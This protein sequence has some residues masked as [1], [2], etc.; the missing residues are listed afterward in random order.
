MKTQMENL[1]PGNFVSARERAVLMGK[2]GTPPPHTH[3]TR[4]TNQGQQEVGEKNISADLGSEIRRG[5]LLEATLSTLFAGE[6][7]Q[8]SSEAVFRMQSRVSVVQPPWGLL[9]QLAAP[10]VF[11]SST[12]QT[13]SQSKG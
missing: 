5:S 7:G 10:S 4:C 8:G 11:I 3:K 9:G 2:S 1:I 6:R 13:S 12:Q